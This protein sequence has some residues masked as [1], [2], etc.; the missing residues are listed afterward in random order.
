MARINQTA[1]DN[2]INRLRNEENIKCTVT[3]N[4]SA[5]YIISH[6]VHQGVS[7][8]VIQRGSGVKTITN[9]TDLCSKCGGTGRC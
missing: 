7:Y 6:L 1:C 4:A 5:K 2:I 8:R 3:D 9:Q